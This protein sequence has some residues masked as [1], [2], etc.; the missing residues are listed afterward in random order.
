MS[1]ERILKTIVHVKFD[2]W[3]ISIITQYFSPQ[4]CKIV[5]SII[6]FMIDITKSIE[7]PSK[8]NSPESHGTKQSNRLDPGSPQKDIIIRLHQLKATKAPCVAKHTKPGP[9]EET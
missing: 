1:M 6:L 2:V 3:H 7:Q 5:E 9:R 8:D 4:Y